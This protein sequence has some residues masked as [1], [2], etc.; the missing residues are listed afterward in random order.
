[1]SVIWD[2]I[3]DEVLGMKWLNELIGTLL[4]ACGLDVSGRIGSSIQFFIY[5]T[6]SAH[7]GIT[8]EKEQKTCSKQ[9]NIGKKY[10]VFITFVMNTRYGL[11]DKT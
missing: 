5:D 1:M 4:T 9:V 2:F 3:Q 7:H 6:I 11:S 10:R 8:K